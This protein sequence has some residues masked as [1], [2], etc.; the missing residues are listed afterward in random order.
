[1]SQHTAIPQA[2]IDRLRQIAEGGLSG[3][4]NLFDRIRYGEVLA[5][6]KQM[7]EAPA[8]ANGGVSVPEVAPQTP[9]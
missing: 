3:D 9:K 4:C 8:G 7:A 1:M 2:T 5:M 6:A